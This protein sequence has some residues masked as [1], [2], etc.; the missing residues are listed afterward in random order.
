[1][2]HLSMRRWTDPAAWDKYLQA[3]ESV[4]DDRLEKLDV[5]DPA[6]RKADVTKGEGSFIVQFGER[7]DSRWLWGKFTKTKIEFEIQHYKAS[8]DSFG[9]FRANSV[10]FYIPERMT[11]GP[12]V[13]RLVELFRLSNEQL[14]TFYAYADFKS[15]ICAKK[16]STPSLDISRELLGVFWLTYFGFHYCSFFGRE[17]LVRLQ[18]VSEWPATGITLQ[19]A[20]TAG[21]VPDDNRTRLERDIAA[22]SFAGTGGPKASGQHALTLAQLTG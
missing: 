14:E 9:R 1:M 17:R 16:P 12:D 6:R 18:Q 8:T 5:N 3:V 21:Q 11:F 7:E 2:S 15:V 19:L 20:D 13:R 22:E 4:L 10:T